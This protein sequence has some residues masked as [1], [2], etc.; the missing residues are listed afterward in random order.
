MSLYGL[1]GLQGTEMEQR[2]ITVGVTKQVPLSHLLLH[3]HIP[4]FLLADDC[5]QDSFRT[6]SGLTCDNADTPQGPAPHRRTED[7]YRWDS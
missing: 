2:W 3:N 4:P 1:I 7:F 6:L 5:I